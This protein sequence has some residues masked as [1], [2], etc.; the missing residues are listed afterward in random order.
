MKKYLLLLA[1]L[2]L[3][4]CLMVEDFGDYWEKGFADKCITEIARANYIDEA[5][6]GKTDEELHSLVRSVTLGDYNYLMMKDEV[7]GKSGMLTLY[8]VKDGQYIAY[9]IKDGMSKT[10]KEEYPN[11]PITLEGD[12]T[13]PIAKAAALT[14]DVVKIIEEI[15][16]REDYWTESTKTPYNPKGLAECKQ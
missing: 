11:A 10:F 9:S 2:T 3:T 16:N 4:G 14:P 15:A 7:G 1:V 13:A 8:E 5:N 12:D 6:K